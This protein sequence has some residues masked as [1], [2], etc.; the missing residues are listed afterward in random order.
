MPFLLIALILGVVQGLC[1]FLPISSSGHLVLAQN[2]FGL[3]E[4]QIAFDVVLHLGTL[5]AVCFYYRHIL[6]NLCLELRFLP[7]ALINFKRMKELYQ[8]RPDFR[9]GLLVII[10]SLPTAFIGFIFADLFSSLFNSVL[11][12][13]LALIVTGFFIKFSGGLKEGHKE[14]AQM[15]IKDAL[16][17]G[18]SQGLA[19]TPGISRSGTT[20]GVALILGLS[21]EL[22]ARYSFIMSIPAILGALVLHLK[23]DLS[24]T[25]AWTDF[26]VG[27]LA[28]A[29]SGYLALRLLV[30][31]LKKN[32]FS[33]FA[34]WCWPVGLLA[35]AWH[36]FG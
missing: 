23:D 25:F 7:G 18:F 30:F 3:E 24:N 8:T 27:F 15:T 31:L 17:I 9:F 36:F 16:I 34:Y 13:G 5:I 35:I 20:I 22:A 2:F 11:A 1:E 33:L 10:G 28:A 21:R 32:N 19:I 29:I 6:I 26:L 12:V 14:A 4:P